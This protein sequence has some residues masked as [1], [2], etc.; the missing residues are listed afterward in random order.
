MIREYNVVVIGGGHAGVEASNICSKL[1]LKTLLVTSSIDNISKIS[2]N[3]SIGGVGKS[4]IV[5]EINAIGGIMPKVADISGLNFK[6]LNSSKGKS[7][8]STRI[9]VDKYIYSRC[10]KLELLK[11]SSLD[12]LQQDVVDIIL[13]NSVVIG[14]VLSFCGIIN[15][16]S[17]IITSGTFLNSKVFIGS[18]VS[19][20]SRD[21]EHTSSLLS[22]KLRYYLKGIGSFKTGT[23]PRIDFRTIDFNRLIEVKS[24]N[25]IP[26]FHKRNRIVTL[27]P[28]CWQGKTNIKTEYIVKS[29]INRSAMYNGLIES[30]GPRYCPSI[31]DKY[32]R[33]PSS[34]LH[35]VFLELECSYGNEVYLGGLSTSFDFKTQSKLV[36]SIVGLERSIITRFG[37]AIEYDF[38]NPKYLKLTLESK[39]IS[40]LFLAG[41]INGTTGYEEA[42][43]QGIVAGINCNSY[44]N[45]IDPVLFN[46]KNSYI[47][48]LIKDITSN[49]VSE[50][51]RMFTS[52]AKNRMNMR[53]DNAKYRLNSFLYSNNLLC[54]DLFDSIERKNLICSNFINYSRSYYL[55]YLGNKVSL[56]NVIL[57][58]KESISIFIKRPVISKAIA[59]F[60]SS[61]SLGM[62]DFIESEIKYSGY[63]K[64]NSKHVPIDIKRPINFNN[65]NNLS[66]ETREKILKYNVSNFYDLKKIKNIRYTCIESVRNYISSRFDN[67]VL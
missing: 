15:C 9:Q 51:Y 42:A 56:F 62:F 50:P 41:Q 3:P 21:N 8:R 10:S 59:C 49:G 26:F 23:P 7:V 28:S 1:G 66:S 46:H 12:I 43:A 64:V 39:Y 22:N 31:E 11:N 13:N 58:N 27:N 20:I 57:N 47:G 14:V 4:Q 18:S 35:T 5:S 63:C 67:R 6:I 29:N 53:Q 55:K 19:N 24:D 65:I 44:I 16:N 61:I 32:L 17:V 54:K 30:I 2:C 36:R 40:G 48:V 45:G 60:G 52:R 37:Y 38:F 34:R 33:F 25:P